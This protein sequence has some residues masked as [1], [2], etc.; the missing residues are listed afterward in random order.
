MITLIIK[1]KGQMVHLPGIAAFRTP[2][3]ID[4][5]SIKLSLIVTV[6]NNSG[7]SDYEIIS[8]DS[9]Q[10]IVYKKKDFELTGKLKEPKQ[11]LSK[12]DHRFNKI[13]QMIYALSKKNSKNNE[14]EEQITNKLNALEEL[15][16]R[17]LEK[18]NV[19]EIVYTSTHDKPPIIEE[20]DGDTFV[21]E[22]DISDM[23]L[24]GTSSKTVGKIEG[25]EEAADML[26]RLKR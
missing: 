22:V 5:S 13:E 19:R 17:I 18:E 9:E 14:P 1:E 24:K 8:N 26:S 15:S 6:L 16:R 4:I 2:A 3:K 25:V 23:K 10:K 7:I 21:P 11:D 20:L 12:I